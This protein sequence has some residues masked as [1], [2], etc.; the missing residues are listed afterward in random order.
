MTSKKL[1]ALFIEIIN[2]SICVNYLQTN[3]VN[4]FWH[5]F[6]L[7][8]YSIN[9]MIKLKKS[10]MK[11]IK[12]K[13][14]LAAASL[15]AMSASFAQD[16]STLPKPDTTNRPS[17][18]TTKMMHDS[19]AS[20]ITLSNS[21]NTVALNSGNASTSSAVAYYAAKKQRKAE[22]K[23]EQATSGRLPE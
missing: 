8:V 16:T 15:F 10:I 18:D 5:H 19:T 9:K 2:I 22:K 20:R 21:D 12:L 7:L 11:S 17:T 4:G 14:L 13:T 1:C 23:S 6:S 3:H